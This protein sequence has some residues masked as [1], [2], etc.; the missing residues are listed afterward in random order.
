MSLLKVKC[1]TCKSAHF[2]HFACSCGA[3]F[4]SATPTVDIKKADGKLARRDF[5]FCPLCGVPIQ[6]E[7]NP[8]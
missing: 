5:R 7:R 2:D 6:K 8:P 3:V 1:S 4:G